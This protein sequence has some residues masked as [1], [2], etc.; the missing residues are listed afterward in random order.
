MIRLSLMPFY[1]ALNSVS[2]QH[3]A[4]IID[5]AGKLH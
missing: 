2:Q 5:I 4:F 3:Y 1:F